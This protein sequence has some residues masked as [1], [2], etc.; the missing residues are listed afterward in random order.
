MRTRARAKPRGAAAKSRS[1]WRAGKPAGALGLRTCGPEEARRGPRGR[2]AFG[3]A[4]RGP[5]TA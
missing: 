4:A 1:R 2:G 5:P 3:P